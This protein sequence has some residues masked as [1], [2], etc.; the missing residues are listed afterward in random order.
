M[1]QEIEDGTIVCKNYN[2][3]DCS[4][5][6]QETENG[7]M[8]TKFKIYFFYAFWV[9]VPAEIILTQ[10][11]DSSPPVTASWGHWRI[12]IEHVIANKASENNI[13][14]GQGK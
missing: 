14:R 11:L 10:G 4:T 5:M 1:L 6:I 3:E 2:T 8:D 12:D 7:I 9:L 13:H